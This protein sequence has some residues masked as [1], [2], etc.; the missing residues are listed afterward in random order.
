LE[1][2]VAQEAAGTA[3]AQIERAQ[4]ERLFLALA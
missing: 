4:L 3:E 1:Q 2:C